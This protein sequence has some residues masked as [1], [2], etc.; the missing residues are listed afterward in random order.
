MVMIGNIS[1]PLKFKMSLSENEMKLIVTKLNPL[2]LFL[3]T[4]FLHGEKSIVG[5]TIY[6]DK[7]DLSILYGCHNHS[8][9]CTTIFLW[10]WQPL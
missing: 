6:I 5:I 7:Y 1:P 2:F 10:M 8:F 9:V 4:I 3:F